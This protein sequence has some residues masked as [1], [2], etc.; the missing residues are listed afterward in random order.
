VSDDFYLTAED[1]RF[2]IRA[3]REAIRAKLSGEAPTYDETPSETVQ[4]P[5]GAFVTLRTT[6]PRKD[7]PDLR[8]CIGHVVATR[9]LA[10]TVKDAAVSAALRDPRF[11]PV[12]LEELADIEIEISVLSPLR[13]VDS[14]EEVVPGTHGVML[15]GFGRSGLLLPQVAT[16][17][18]WDRETFLTHCCFKAGLTGDCWHNPAT[19]IQ[20]FTAI[21]FEE[22]DVE[23]AG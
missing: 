8:G 13:T 15:T 3:A 11:S 23:G 17:H 6:A 1:K 14:P 7:E 20:V 16:E 4:A 10:E 19:E 2:L 22:S 9:P 12:T 18:G 21:V 5:A